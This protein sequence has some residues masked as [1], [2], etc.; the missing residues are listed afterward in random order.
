MILTVILYFSFLEKARNKNTFKKFVFIIILFAFLLNFAW[1]IIQI[2]LYK[3][4]SYS[5]MHIT[6]CALASVADAI[7]VLLIY[8][9]LGF[10][11]K[12]SLWIQKLTWYKVLLIISIGGTGAALT[13][14]WYL[15]LA[16]WSYA[17]AMPIIPVVNVGLSP[18][19]QF[20][21]LPLLVY[22]LSFNFLEWIAK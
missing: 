18:I 16:N 11:F 20:M 8:L 13:E 9:V 22:R 2:P 5:L 7:V 19:L 14:I 4:S 12:N 10:I 3:N 15:S 6:F 1:E 17:D 21:I